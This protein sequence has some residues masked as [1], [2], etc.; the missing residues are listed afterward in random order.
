[1][2][3]WHQPTAPTAFVHPP[4]QPPFISS[5]GAT[6]K[7]S[8]SRQPCTAPLA[9]AGVRR[10]C[11]PAP[12]VAPALHPC[13]PPRSSV[14]ATRAACACFVLQRRSSRPH[15]LHRYSR[16][17]C[18]ACGR[19]LQ[20]P[21]PWP[22]ARQ[23]RRPRPRPCQQPHHLPRSPSCVGSPLRHLFPPAGRPPRRQMRSPPLRRRR[24]G[25]SSPIQASPLRAQPSRHAY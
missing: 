10:P 15:R 18:H 6:A 13:D 12:L 1:M 25:C 22:A 2:A 24:V 9:T 16:P 8:S 11:P 14:A 5:A 7:R 17:R 20:E 21:R 4:L 3:A 23:P 19:L